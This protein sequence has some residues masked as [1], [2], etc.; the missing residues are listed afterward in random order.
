MLTETILVFLVAASTSG[1]FT[2]LWC[3]LA[4]AIGLTDRPDGHRKIHGRPTPVGGGVA[5][6]G[7]LL[8]VLVGLMAMPN[9]FRLG[10]WE[11]ASS[12]GPLLA[13]GAVI[14][15][16][17][18]IDDRFALR[19][20]QKLL[21]QILAASLVM[22]G[23][24]SIRQIGILGWQV[25]LGLVAPLFTLFWLLGAINAL[26]LLDGIDGLA[27]AVGLIA[28]SV[29]GAMAVQVGRV[30][31]AVIALV[32][33]ATLVGFLRFNFPPAR[34]FLGDT[35]SMLIGLVVGVLAIQGS[36]KGAGTVLLA[37]PLA[38]C[39]VPIF[40]VT[41]AILRR[42]LT[43]RSIYAT[44]RGH[45]HHCL[46]DR[47]GSNRKVLFWIAGTC[48]LTSGAALVS[49]YRKSD[50]IALVTI[51]AVVVIFVATRMFGHVEFLLL[52]SHV[53]KLGLSFLGR[54]G[55]RSRAATTTYCL[56]NSPRWSLLWEALTEAAE[57][58]CLARIRLDVDLPASQEGYHAL[59]E[60]P[61]PDD[62]E[63]CWRIDVP[64]M[65]RNRL[66]GHLVVFGQRTWGPARLDVERLL[67]LLEPFESELDRAPEPV[68]PRQAAMEPACVAQAHEASS[69][70]R[71]PSAL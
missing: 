11:S 66:L 71:S 32:F 31:V 47:F 63:R 2:A 17:G 8:A 51:G 25:E 7:A 56:N 4:P 28:V 22:L 35:G 21:G 16:V 13:A 68:R 19:G 45:L 26:N 50:L 40:D 33:A 15:A 60:G 34:V 54:A 61:R 57:D 55:A 36:L 39:T 46:L 62:L 3:R 1:L 53:R 5:I 9:P 64:L 65:A 49:V 12:L 43:G 38:I 29:I 52:K 70:S 42:K 14:V 67:D 58:L 10:L 30:E 37:A 23:G 59:W 6:Y 69:P 18:L 41:A 48:A 24:L 27:A 20:R 44:D